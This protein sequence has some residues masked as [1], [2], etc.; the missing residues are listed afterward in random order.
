MEDYFRDIV[1]NELSSTLY[2]SVTKRIENINKRVKVKALKL[3]FNKKNYLNSYTDNFYLFEKLIL[4]LIQQKM[5]NKPDIQI[6]TSDYTQVVKKS[7]TEK[8]FR[9]EIQMLEQEAQQIK[10]ERENLELSKKELEDQT[11]AKKKKQELIEDMQKK[12]KI[13]KEEIFKQKK[14]LNESSPLQKMKPKYVEMEEAYKANVEIIEIEKAQAEFARKKQ[15]LQPLSRDDFTLH[16]KRYKEYTDEAKRR[17]EIRLQE[18]NIENSLNSIQPIKNSEIVEKEELAQIKRTMI[19]RKKQYGNLVRELFGPKHDIHVH[20]SERA[21]FKKKTP[22]LS[23]ITPEYRNKKDKKE[24]LLPWKSVKKVPKKYSDQ[25][26][27]KKPPFKYNY[28]SELRIKRTFI[29]DSYLENALN[30]LY[31]RSEFMDKSEMLKKLKDAEKIAMKG[32]NKIKFSDK[33]SISGINL[34]EKLNELLIQ[35]VKAKADM[36]HY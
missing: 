15:T 31:Q 32:E 11:L 34:E 6:D 36:L 8:K 26:T 35:S 33:N 18:I 29:D 13:R 17:R 21:D 27:E 10:Q 30:G 14:I 9:K 12:A 7:K 24:T 19:E 1:K 22:P 28:L 5:K 20:I 23:P 16:E 2:K 25:E 4:R 3:N